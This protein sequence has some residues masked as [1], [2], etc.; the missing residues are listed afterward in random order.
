MVS[1]SNLMKSHPTSSA[2][3]RRLRRQ[4]SQFRID[5]RQLA[6]RGAWAAATRLLQA[7]AGRELGKADGICRGFWGYLRTR[8]IMDI[9]KIIEIFAWQ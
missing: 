2:A 9:T 7:G 1:F 4:E 3:T 6:A 5:L 8:K